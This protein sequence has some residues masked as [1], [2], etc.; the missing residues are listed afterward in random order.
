VL[1]REK[2]CPLPPRHPVLLRKPPDLLSAGAA[3]GQRTF[4]R[5]RRQAR[6]L[7]I[8]ES[9]VVSVYYHRLPE[10]SIGEGGL[11]AESPYLQSSATS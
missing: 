2:G 9:V 3:C 5:A 11:L 6:G 8:T 4:P 1:S 10:K 7:T